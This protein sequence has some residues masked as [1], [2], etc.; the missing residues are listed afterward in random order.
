MIDFTVHDAAGEVVDGDVDVPQPFED[1]WK[2]AR[3]DDTWVADRIDEHVLTVDTLLGDAVDVR[4]SEPLWSGG[5]DALIDA[6]GS[7]GAACARRESPCVSAQRSSISRHF[8][9]C[10]ELD[11]SSGRQV[12]RTAVAA[13]V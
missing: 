10:R 1:L 6:S 9:Q 8:W 4:P 13:Q 7:C 12:R 11:S 3:V 5:A 2:F